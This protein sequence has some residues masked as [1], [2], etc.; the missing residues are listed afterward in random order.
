[1]SVLVTQGGTEGGRKRWKVRGREEKSEE[2]GRDERERGEG[3]E[4]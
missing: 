2:R 4:G 3:R 1:M